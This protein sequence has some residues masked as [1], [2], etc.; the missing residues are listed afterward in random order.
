[1]LYGMY[2]IGL[3]TGFYK[4]LTP[5]FNLISDTSTDSTN[6]RTQ[7]IFDIP[8]PEDI[9][10]VIGDDGLHNLVVEADTI[11]NGMVRLFGGEF[12]ALKLSLDEE[13]THWTNYETGT[14]KI[15]SSQFS[16]YPAEDIKFIWESAR[17][18]WGY[19][20]ARAYHLTQDERYPE[21]FWNY[22][23]AFHKANPVNLGPQWVSAQEVALRLLSFVFCGEVF[24]NSSSSSDVRKTWLAKSVAY[25]AQ[26]IMVTL[27]YA[28]AQNNNHLLSEAAGLIT[29]SLVIPEH[30]DAR[31]WHRVGWKWLN[32]GLETQIN[33][34]GVYTQQ[35]TN[36]HR[37]MLQLA[38]W[39]QTIQKNS[40]EGD[41]RRRKSELLQFVG[42]TFSEKA[43]SNLSLAVKWQIAHMDIK[44]GQ[45]PNLGPNDGAYILPLTVQPFHDYRPVIQAASKIFWGR[46]FFNPG[47]WDEMNLWFDD[48]LDDT[49]VSRF[50]DFKSG[51]PIPVPDVIHHPYNKSWIYLRVAKFSNRPGHA[52]QLHADLWWRGFYIAQDAGSYLYN[53][54]PPWD[55]SLTHTA[56]HNTVLLDGFEQM[57]RVGRFLYL[58]RAQGEFITPN[59][60]EAGSE[61][62]LTARHYGYK[63]FGVY[64]DRS[65]SFQLGGSWQIEDYIHPVDTSSICKSH[66]VRLHW[67]LPDWEYKSL[68]SGFG[69]LLRSPFGWVTLNI[70][71]LG[72]NQ[73]H[74]PGLAISIIRAGK[75]VFGSGPVSPNW[76]W[77]SPT[78]GVKNPALSFGVS[79]YGLLPLTIISEWVFPED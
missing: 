7:R 21:A 38:L 54:V 19:T 24:A 12:V 74:I 25:H 33:G 44:T 40:S 53:G 63:R 45:V 34:D 17:F 37:L 77:V 22:F 78:Y 72:E 5:I 47:P 29:S 56:V 9:I 71:A 2:R 20:L 55:N 49:R 13:L 64:H 58:D 42:P 52:D 8:S 10:D 70:S 76:G 51:K 57:T 31:K 27:I 46:K 69:L 43:W 15:S 14:S 65:V 23:E 18:G 16:G 39:I 28:R 35:S 61:I 30:P 60:D 11:L 32:Y 41:K 48:I 75:L 3:R 68:E 26:R 66:S 62:Q 1:M 59:V 73:E 67:L 36:Y 4:H 6:I 50:P 79:F